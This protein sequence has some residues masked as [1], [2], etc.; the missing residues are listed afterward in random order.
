MSKNNIPH[1]EWLGERLVGLIEGAKSAIED[2]DDQIKLWGPDAKYYFDNGLTLQEVRQKR[3]SDISNSQ[4][5]IKWL[6]D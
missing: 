5:L 1:S 4:D 2:I 6:Q 3:E